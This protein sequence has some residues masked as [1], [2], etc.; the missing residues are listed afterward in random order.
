MWGDEAKR[1]QLIA[2]MYKRWE[3]SEAREQMAAA[4]RG[5]KCITNGM[6]NK[7][8]RPGEDIPVGFKFG[9]TKSLR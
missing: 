6:I 7:M 9:K 8:I 1:Q 5:L 4:K 2:G 3:S